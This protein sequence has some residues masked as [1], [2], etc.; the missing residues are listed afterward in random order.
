MVNV[1]VMALMLTVVVAVGVVPL[2]VEG[3]RDLKQGEQ[4]VHPQ[5][6]IGGAGGL[7]GIMPIPG[8]GA[9]GAGGF[10]PPGLGSSVDFCSFPGLGCVRV[11]PTNPG[12]GAGAGT[13]GGGIGGSTPLPFP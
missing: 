4:A 1:K 8:G 13:I 7:G 12:A 11:Q 3:G 9:A 10:V 2:L 6:F 5:N